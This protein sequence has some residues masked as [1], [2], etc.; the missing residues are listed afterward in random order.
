MQKK[1][2]STLALVL[3]GCRFLNAFGNIMSAF[4][5]SNLFGGIMGILGVF[6]WWNIYNFKRWALTVLNV[7]MVLH[8]LS[9][10]VALFQGGYIFTCLLGMIY[11]G[12]NLFYF[13]SSKIKIL[14]Q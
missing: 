3:I 12:L 8:L 1:E 2:W 11:A 9:S 10:F 13:N 7:L 4:S 14:F 6:V 5:I